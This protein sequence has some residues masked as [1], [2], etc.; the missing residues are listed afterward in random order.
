[1]ELR[2]DPEDGRLLHRLLGRS[3]GDLRAEITKTEK[4][5]WRKAMQADEERLVSIIHRLEAVTA[6]V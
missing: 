2:L 1:M 5:E 4:Y 6:A 3:L